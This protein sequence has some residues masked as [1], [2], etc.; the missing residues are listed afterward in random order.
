MI[1]QGYSRFAISSRHMSALQCT[2]DCDEK[3]DV[4]H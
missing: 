4:D 1:H 2:A 3:L